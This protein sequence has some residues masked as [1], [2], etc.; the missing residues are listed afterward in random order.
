MRSDKVM[1]LLIGLLAGALLCCAGSGVLLALSP[2]QAA[3]EGWAPAA[4][5]VIQAD[6]TEAYLNRTFLSYTASIPSPLP[7]KAGHLDVLP[8]NQMAFT[9]QMQSPL[10][11]LTAKGIATIVARDGRLHIGVSE[12]HLGPVPVT[13]LMRL[14]QPGLETQINAMANDQI[15]SRLGQANLTL[16]A[17]TSDEGQLHFYFTSR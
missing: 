11:L 13:L 12:V 3:V 16:A 2:A 6:V 5:A 1:A 8:G 4:D 14:T 10:G 7:I 15:L 17:V 9:A